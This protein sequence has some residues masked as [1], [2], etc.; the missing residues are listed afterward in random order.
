MPGA[1]RLA[2]VCTGHDSCPPRPWVTASPCVIINGR[3][4]VRIAD[5]LAAHGCIVHPSHTA[6][7]TSGSG[8]VIV[9]GRPKGRKNAWDSTSC[10]SRTNTGSPCVI[11]NG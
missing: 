9:N 10:P 7:L 11:T 5:M 2:D 6:V 1:V 3:G 8:C 4:S